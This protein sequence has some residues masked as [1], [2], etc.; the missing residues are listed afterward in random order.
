MCINH[1]SNCKNKG[2]IDTKTKLVLK[3]LAN[4]CRDGN[5]KI[6]EISDIIMSLPKRFRVEPDAVKHILTYLERQDMI[7]IKYDDDGVFCLAVLPYGFEILEDE[8][9]KMFKKEHSRNKKFNI[10]PI[11]TSFLS[12]LLGASI[13]ILIFYF[14]LK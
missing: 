2:M 11:L 1:Q 13:G 8:D 7:S 14:V 9:S 3:S 4:Q 5:Y 12:A 10:F 6:V